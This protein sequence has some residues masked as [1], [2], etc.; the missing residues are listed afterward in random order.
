MT[1]AERLKQLSGLLTGTAGSMF[2]S[3][4]SGGVSTKHTVVVP[5]VLVPVI[6]KEI[7]VNPTNTAVTAPVLSI[8]VNKVANEATSTIV[9]RSTPSIVTIVK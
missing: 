3:I 7:V 9:P 5:D 1:A 4:V 6:V 8:V 2:R